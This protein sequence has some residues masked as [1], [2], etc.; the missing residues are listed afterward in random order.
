M[1]KLRVIICFL[2]LFGSLSAMAITFSEQAKANNQLA[3]SVNQTLTLI[4]PIDTAHY[5]IPKDSIAAVYVWGSASDYKNA[6]AACKMT[7]FS[8]DSCYYKTYT[9]EDIARP[10][11]SGQPEFEFYTQ[12]TNGDVVYY[13][14]DMMRHPAYDEPL[15]F[16]NSVTPV[17][18]LLPGGPDYLQT[19]LDELRERGEVA[20]EQRALSDY[21]LT[22]SIDQYRIS[23]F[24]RVPGTYNLYR[25]YHPYY[26]SIR[27]H[28]TEV[29]RLQW[30]A[31]LAE[32]VGIKS[33][34]CLTGD[35]S[36]RVGETFVCA[37]DTH[38]ITIPTYLQTI[39]EEGHTCY[40]EASTSQC[41]YYTD[42]DRF[43]E[44]IQRVVQFIADENTPLPI[45]IHCALG[46][47]RTGVVCAVLS[48]LCGADWESIAEDYYATTY[49]RLQM[50][51]H[52]N[53]LIYALQR[54]TGLR[55][56]KCTNLQLVAA[57]RHHLVNEKQVLTDEQINRM[58]QRL[59]LPIQTS[60]ESVNIDVE[61]NIYYDILGRPVT[62]DYS[63]VIIKLNRKKIQ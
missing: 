50:Y 52:P 10:G 16:Y 21:D 26:P 43:A 7:D 8:E 1:S 62:S 57:I 27:N 28:D 31:I 58:V 32:E 56:D 20:R 59:T 48:A 14:P 24:R 55:A 44:Y 19:N 45:Q 37:G 63:G 60:L 41:Y 42:G 17:L 51:R 33:D 36:N 49:M 53:R 15:M 5:N 46:A 38:V 29:E 2:S 23:N 35:L 4:F 54:M 3:D 11:D 22:D 47:D 13:T 40:I 39:M 30:V 61:N 18:V 34:I 12:L 6:I 9:Y 25:S